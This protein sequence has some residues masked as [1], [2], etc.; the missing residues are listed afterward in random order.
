M[1]WC[2]RLRLNR[3]FSGW[4]FIIRRHYWPIHMSTLTT[5]DI[6][7][8]LFFFLFGGRKCW[9]RFDAVLFHLFLLYVCFPFSVERGGTCATGLSIGCKIAIEFFQ[10]S[11]L[12]VDRRAQFPDRS[13]FS[14]L[15]KEEKLLYFFSPLKHSQKKK[16]KKKKKNL[17]VTFERSLLIST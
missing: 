10:K 17:Q 5:K 12:S 2:S 9:K 8:F 16:M 1:K 6:F 7:Q 11:G 3:I 4:H 13:T 15:P 14:T